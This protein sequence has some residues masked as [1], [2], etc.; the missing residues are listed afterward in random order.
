[1]SIWFVDQ[2]LW[3]LM[4]LLIPLRVLQVSHD[5]SFMLPEVNIA[6]KKR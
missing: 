2:I 1:M 5:P 4:T 6:A 3:L